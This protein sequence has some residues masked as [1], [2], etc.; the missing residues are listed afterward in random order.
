MSE[1]IFDLGFDI[2][3]S[4]DTENEESYEVDSSEVEP[5]ECPFVIR[6]DSNEQLPYLFQNIVGD[7]KSD[8]APIKVRTIKKPVKPAG[9]Y[10]IEGMPEIAIERKSK[11]D[12]F[13]SMASNSKRDNFIDRLRKMQSTLKYGAVVIECYPDELYENPSE[14]TKINPKTLYRST[15]SWAQQFPLIHWHWCKNRQWAEQVV[16]RILEKFYQHETDTKYKH[17]NKVIDS[18]EEA[19]RLGVLARMTGKEIEALYGQG[20]PL[21]LSW[22]RGIDFYSTNWLSGERAIIYEQGEL[23]PSE[24]ALAVAEHKKA[25]KSKNI[26]G[27]QRKPLKGQRSFIEEPKDPLDGLVDQ[28]EKSINKSKK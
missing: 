6:R 9:D 25:K 26:D 17:H 12:F 23:P 16:F 27:V 15:L 8:Y 5:R 7:S 28:I 2:E 22:L 11:A 3:D 24:V 4:Q 13:S 1:S 14:H 19:F 18:H 20:N 10:S 21:R